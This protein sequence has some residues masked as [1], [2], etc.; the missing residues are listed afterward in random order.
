[1]VIEKL[2]SKQKQL[3]KW[4]HK[5]DGFDNII[6]DGAVRS[7]KTIIMGISF[8]HWAMRYFNNKSFAFIGKT[9]RSCERN[10]ITPLL[11]CND[12]TDFFKLEYQR[13]NGIL[14]VK[15]KYT[16]EFVFNMLDLAS[17]DDSMQIKVKMFEYKTLE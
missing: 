11:S 16:Q 5:E 12:I 15:V 3:L 10:I 2:S 7:G 4:C 1:M 9:N 6:C 14:T 8:I 17:F 13:S